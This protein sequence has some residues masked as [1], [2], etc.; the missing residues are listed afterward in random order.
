MEN[1]LASG[2]QEDCPL[3]LG[4]EAGENL[5]LSAEAAEAISTEAFSEYAG[6]LNTYLQVAWRLTFQ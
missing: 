2:L 5:E 6:Q 1:L 3:D 4:E